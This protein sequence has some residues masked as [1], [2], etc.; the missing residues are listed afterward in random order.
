MADVLGGFM[1]W[2]NGVRDFMTTK[3]AGFTLAEYILLGLTTV[4][5]AGLIAS[6]LS[7]LGF[8]PLVTSVLGG[9][10]VFALSAMFAVKTLQGVAKGDLKTVKDENAAILAA[11]VLGLL[12][13][14]F[15]VQL[16]WAPTATKAAQMVIASVFPP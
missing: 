6:A 5:Y 7:M 4:A 9:A 10:A 11:L 2:F 3:F 16:P 13:A 8:G 15:V 1:D 12:M 14:T